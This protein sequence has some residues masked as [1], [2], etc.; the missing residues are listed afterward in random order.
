MGLMRNWIGA[1]LL[2]AAALA[3][4]AFGQSEDIKERLKKVRREVKRV[5]LPTSIPRV[6]ALFARENEYADVLRKLGD[7]ERNKLKTVPQLLGQARDL[8][9]AT[10]KDLNEILKL[11][12]SKHMGISEKEIHNRLQ[13]QF[14]GVNYEEEWLVNI[15]DDIEDACEIN[16]EMDA[17]IYKFDSVTFEFE[18]TSARAMLQMM[19]DELLFEWVIRGDTLYVYK[20][21]N[22]VLFGKSW[23]RAKKRAEKERAKREKARKGMK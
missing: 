2:V 15:L 5:D 19:A 10:L 23:V 20:E 1:L 12:K 16:I 8:K 13:R 9:V 17:R 6:P 4:Y 3:G 22:E 11:H 21:R 18:S 7:A 14:T